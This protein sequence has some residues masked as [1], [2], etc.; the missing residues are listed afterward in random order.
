MF[1]IAIGGEGGGERQFLILV[2]HILSEQ[3]GDQ[4]LNENARADDGRY[5]IAGQAE[6]ALPAEAPEHERLAGAHRDL[7]ETEVHASIEEGALDEIMLADRCAP[8]SHKN[9]RAV[10]AG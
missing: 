3:R 2:F 9:I 5:R 1:A 6:H 7:P 8:E 10:G 4:R